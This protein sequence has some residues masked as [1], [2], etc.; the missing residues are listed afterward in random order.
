MTNHDITTLSFNFNCWPKVDPAHQLNLLLYTKR[1]KIL[2]SSFVNIETGTSN[3]YYAK[4]SHAPGT[5]PILQAAAN[6]EPIER[7]SKPR[8]Y[9]LSIIHAVTRRS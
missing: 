9:L 4:S 2:H 1:K 3:S 8:L 5:P 6:Y 7:K